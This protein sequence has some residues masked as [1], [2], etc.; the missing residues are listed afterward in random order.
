MNSNISG[1]TLI[2]HNNSNSNNEIATIF[3]STTN[4]SS[5]SN[6][7]SMMS[8]SPTATIT[9]SKFIDADPD[10]DHDRGKIVLRGI[11]EEEDNI[12][13]TEQRMEL[14]KRK[15]LNLSYIYDNESPFLSDPQQQKS[16]F[17][18]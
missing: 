1:K 8:S 6:T 12:M 4:T 9:T 16:T 2:N 5:N 18:L 15:G 3:N 13:L 14:D 17:H 11:S 10:L 7:Y